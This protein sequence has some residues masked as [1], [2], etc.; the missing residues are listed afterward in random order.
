[1]S[2]NNFTILIVDNYHDD[3]TMLNDVLSNDYNLVHADN[4]KSAMDTA[5]RCTP[6][7]ILVN[8][9]SSDI[10]KSL[11]IC[12]KLKNCSLTQGIPVISMVPSSNTLNDKENLELGVVDCIVKPFNA[13]ELYSQ[14]KI[15]L[16]LRT[17]FNHFR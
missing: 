17:P 2:Q 3:T 16:L 4:D 13:T 15:N 1:M 8:F 9:Q 7:L 12:N 10:K 5:L 6:S 14:I 11:G